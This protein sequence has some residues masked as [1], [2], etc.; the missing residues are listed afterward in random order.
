MSDDL[1][2]INA[3]RAKVFGRE[4]EVLRKRYLQ[5][6]ETLGRLTADAPTEHLAHE[7]ARLQKEI[8][9]AMAKLDEL[10][11]GSEATPTATTER[12]P[13]T[14]PPP[15][16]PRPLTQPSGAVPPTGERRAWQTAPIAPTPEPEP[17]PTGDGLRSSIGI[18]AAGIVVLAVIALLV[19]YFLSAEKPPEAFQDNPAVST[20]PVITETHA[21]APAVQPLPLS[22]TPSDFNYGTIRKGTRATHQFT[23]ANGTDTP[24]TIATSRSTCRCLWFKHA[25]SIPPHGTTSLTIT[26]DGGRAKKG[27]VDEQVQV[28]AKGTTQIMAAIHVVA[29]VE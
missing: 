9:S 15:P 12:T 3:N 5:H 23:L 29:N 25:P 28:S 27:A 11:R 22:A 17:A 16:P 1:N 19:W 24:I 20:S 4:V 2:T 14:P 7:Y 26:V 21:P 18:V 13:L 6:R 10:E 8:D